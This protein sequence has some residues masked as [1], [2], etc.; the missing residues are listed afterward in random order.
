MTDTSLIGAIT[1]LVPTVHVNGFDFTLC[2]QNVPS[3]LSRFMLCVLEAEN[4]TVQDL[5]SQ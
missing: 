5:I 3:F 4:Y 1:S 2:V